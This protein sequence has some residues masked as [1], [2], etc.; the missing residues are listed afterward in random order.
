MITMKM[1]RRPMASNQSGVNANDN[2]E[3]E[4]ETNQTNQSGAN[5]NDNNENEEEANV[6]QSRW[7][8]YK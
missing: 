3:N 2:S 1:K 7:S 4:E 6:K 8:G 5:A